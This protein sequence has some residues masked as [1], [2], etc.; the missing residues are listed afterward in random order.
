VRH[1]LALGLELNVREDASP[2]VLETVR[3]ILQLCGG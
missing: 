2:G 1:E 3:E